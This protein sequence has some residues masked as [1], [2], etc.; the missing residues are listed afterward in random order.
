MDL[1]NKLLSSDL[2]NERP[3]SI[4][5]VLLHPFFTIEASLGVLKSQQTLRRLM[6]DWSCIC[7]KLSVK[8]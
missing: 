1:L 8:I 7:S 5:K 3:H 4:D 2:T 6:L